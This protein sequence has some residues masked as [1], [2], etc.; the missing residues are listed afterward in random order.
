MLYRHLIDLTTSKAGKYEVQR[1]KEESN[2]DKF[3]GSEL[4]NHLHKVA[5]AITG[6]GN[7]NI[8]LQELASRL[9]LDSRQLVEKT[10]LV[11]QKNKL[12]KL[13][14]SFFFRTGSHLGCEFQHKSF[15]EYL[16]A[17]AIIEKLKEYG[18]NQEK[19]GFIPEERKQY[20]KDFPNDDLRYDFSRDLL[21]ML[22]T[23]PLTLEIYRYLDKLIEWEVKRFKTQKSNKIGLPTLPANLD[24]WKQIRTALCD[25]WEWW[26]G[27]N[28]SSPTKGF[29]RKEEISI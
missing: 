17:E 15:R 24:E 14:I 7:E 29:N 27:R 26:G 3:F 18:R 16:F 21:D 2:Q 1:E 22:G 19:Q 23:K 12:S 9:N 4:R 5:I 6:Y 13:L 28:A 11:E 10:E 8:P 20:W 25:L